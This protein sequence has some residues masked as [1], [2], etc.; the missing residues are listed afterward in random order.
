MAVQ[1]WAGEP[2]LRFRGSC[3]PVVRGI[4][5]PCSCSPAWLPPAGLFRSD[6]GRN[7]D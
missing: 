5:A 4:T 6:L 3:Y 1:L 7:Q 2:Y